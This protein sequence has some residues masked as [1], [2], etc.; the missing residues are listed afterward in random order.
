MGDE[1]V[2]DYLKRACDQRLKDGGR[3]DAQFM[4]ALVRRV[5]STI[6]AQTDQPRVQLKRCSLTTSWCDSNSFKAAKC[7]Q[8]QQPETQQGLAGTGVAAAAWTM[9]TLPEGAAA[10]A[11]AAAAHD[12][13]G[14]GEEGGG[15]EGA[16]EEVE[17]LEEEDA[18]ED[19]V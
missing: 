7:M 14:E 4:E 12:E 15:E 8:Q 2:H 9:P 16:R 5:N 10:W 19:E 1:Y 3:R 17:E 11:A 18:E 13:A 6:S